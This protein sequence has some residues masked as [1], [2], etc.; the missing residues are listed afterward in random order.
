MEHR[1]YDGRTYEVLR[2]SLVQRDAMALELW[3]TTEGGRCLVLQVFYSDAYG[4]MTISLFKSELPLELVEW[5][6]R[7]ARELLPPENDPHAPTM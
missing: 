6:V 5:F 1:C 2:V 7:R 4:K 3:D